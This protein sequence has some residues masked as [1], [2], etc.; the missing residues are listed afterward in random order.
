MVAPKAS[1]WQ[2]R[3]AMLRVQ[4]SAP[5]VDY[6]ALL[7]NLELRAFVVDDSE[8]MRTLLGRLLLRMG[9]KAEGYED[10]SKA[11]A[12]VEAEKPDVILTDYSMEPM[13]GLTFLRALRHLKNDKVR[14]TPVIMITGHAERERIKSARDAGVNEILVK[15]VT[16][17]GIQT[18]IEEVILRPR[19]WVETTLYCGPCRRRRN[20]QNYEGP[21][22]RKQDNS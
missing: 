6:T 15:P 4:G 9:I 1:S 7:S 19:R 11:L 8:H 10:G 16:Q 20:D 22:R 17:G 12:A 21:E 13:D 14:M 5:L 18:R 2:D 3:V